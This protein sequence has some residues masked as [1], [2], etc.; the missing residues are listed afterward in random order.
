MVEKIRSKISS[1]PENVRIGLK[2]L[3]MSAEKDF[4]STDREKYRDTFDA[5]F[6]STRFVLL[7]DTHII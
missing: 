5:A 4:V 6:V 2:F 3:P 7:I 1:K